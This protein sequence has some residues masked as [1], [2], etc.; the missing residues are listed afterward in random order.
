MRD[1][2]AVEALPKEMDYSLLLPP[3]NSNSGFDNIADLLFVSPT[4]MESYLGAA[5]KISRLA[6]GDP[7]APPLVNIYRV[8]DEQPQN[9]RVE[10]LPFGTR[11]RPRGPQ[12]FSGGRRVPHQSDL[13]GPIRRSRSRW[14]SRSMANE[15]SWCPARFVRPPR[16]EESRAKSVAAD[17]AIDNDDDPDT[18]PGYE[19]GR[20]PIEFR[21]PVKAGPRLIGVAFLEKDEVRDEEVLRPRMRGAG[22]EIGVGV[23]TISGPFN[24]KGPGDTLSRS[25]FLSAARQRPPRKI[26]ARTESSLSGASSLPPA[27]HPE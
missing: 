5:E 2:L 25:A 27:R 1:L 26:P 20:R 16:P 15:R 13:R 22:A 14:N 4:A 10:G 8:P 17:A 7:G 9:V 12:L 24:A 3:D 19:D 18:A 21:V 11:G 23:V 6:V